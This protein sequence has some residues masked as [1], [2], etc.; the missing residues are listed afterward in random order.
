[1][2]AEALNGRA[3]GEDGRGPPAEGSAA[4]AP[5][6]D[7]LG[8]RSMVNYSVGREFKLFGLL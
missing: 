1:M 3:L 4:R 2:C 5:E 8:A 6:Q 7:A